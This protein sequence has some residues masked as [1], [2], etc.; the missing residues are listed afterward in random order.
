MRG[1]EDSGIIRQKHFI[2]FPPLDL[3]NYSCPEKVQERRSGMN[4]ER[5]VM[6]KAVSFLMGMI[7]ILGLCFDAA[8]ENAG[9]P[10]RPESGRVA[11]FAALSAGTEDAEEVPAEAYILHVLDQFDTPVAGVAVNFCTDTACYLRESDEDGMIVFDG[12]PE[13]YHVQVLLVPEG[14]SFE[15]NL[16]L[17]TTAEY[18]EWVLQIRKDGSFEEKNKDD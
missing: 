4:R 14:Y 8:A 2:D 1:G 17:Y 15:E 6:K 5:Y 12:A 18:G 3:T 7:L 10:V 16:E 11:D 13:I 9:D